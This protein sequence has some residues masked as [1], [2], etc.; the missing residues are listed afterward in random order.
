MNLFKTYIFLILKKIDAKAAVDYRPINITT[1]LYKVIARILLERPKKVL[2]LTIKE[3][4]MVYVADRQIID[5]S[6]NANELID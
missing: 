6:L 4:Q 5:A 2:P 3:N 1:C